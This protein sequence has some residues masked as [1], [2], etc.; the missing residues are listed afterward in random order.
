[1]GQRDILIDGIR[2]PHTGHILFSRI[3]HLLTTSIAE[4]NCQ[5]VLIDR[6]SHFPQKGK[7]L[8]RGLA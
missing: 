7:N 6:A 5:K 8:S 2:V 1:M 4:I 3:A